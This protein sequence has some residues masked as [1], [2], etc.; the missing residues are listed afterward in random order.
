MR[1]FYFICLIS[2][3]GMNPI[4]SQKWD[5]TCSQM[6]TF[7]NVG[8][9]VLYADSNYL[10]MAGRFHV[11][12]NTH[13]QG[14]ARWNGVKWEPMGAGIDGLKYISDSSANGNPNNTFAIT[15]YH[16]KLYVGGVFYSLGNVN[17]GA[18][19][20]WDGTTW[21]AVTIPPFKV[22]NMGPTGT[23]GALVVV[24]NRLYMGG[25]FDTV[26][27]IPCIGIA[28]WNDTNWSSLNFPS[29]MDD[30]GQIDA[31]CEYQGSIYVGGIF[32]GTRTDSVQNI[33]RW[34]GT[35]W[36]TVGKGIP[37]SLSDVWCMTVYNGELY[38]GGEFSTSDGNAGNNIEK[39]DG[40]KWSDVGGGTDYQIENM[41]VYNGKL[42][43]MGPFTKAGGVPTDGI[44]EWDG[45]KW[46]SMDTMTTDNADPLSATIYK[47][48]LYVGGVFL[49]IDGDS[50]SFVAE[51]VGGDYTD[52]CGTISTAGVSEVK[53]KNEEVKVYPNP[54]NGIFQLEITNYKSGI[55]NEV[56][57]YNVLGQQIYQ[58]NINSDNTEINLS[59]QPQGVYL[60][61]L[62]NESGGLI[63]E[64]KVVIQN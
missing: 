29:N 16:N 47:D 49:K 44:A 33:L 14:I 1:R 12:N 7:Y 6:N 41:T 20:T 13:M 50:I 36:Y 57:I 38:V 9:D 22:T 2:C 52:S 60:Y 55:N 18:I 24:N 46:C 45:T 61:R 32:A 59:G 10:Y 3:I 25:E 54:S 26:A 34:D 56:E 37:G 63:G 17:A 27:G 42:Y 21:N 28:C 8:V 23:V 64:G 4:F 30:F 62:I 53:V 40:T 58:S 15:T 35:R 51:W 43:A 31:I 39:W 5:S 48:S 19:G 11:I